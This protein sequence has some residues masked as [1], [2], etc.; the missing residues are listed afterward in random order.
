MKLFHTL[1][2]CLLLTAS[3]GY[4]SAKEYK[5]DD[6]P[7]VHLQDRT[8][9]AIN[10]DGILSA[11]T[12]AAIDTSLFALEQ[13]TGIQVMVAALENIEGGDCFEFA[14]QLGQRH[15][16]GRKEQNSGL[17]ILLVTGERCIQFATGY[18][19]EGVLPDATCK[20]IQV[21]YMNQ[22]FGRGDWDEGMLAGIRV[23]K[24]ILDGSGEFTPGQDDE[25]DDADLWL[26][27]GVGFFCLIVVPALLW[28]DYRQR[29][30]CPHCH[31]YALHEVSRRVLSR[32]GGVR[33]E[34]VTYVCRKCGHT[35]QRTHRHN[36]NNDINRRGGNSGPFIGGMGG[37]LGRGGGFGRGGFGGGSFGGGSFGGG[38]A[39]SKF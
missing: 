36:E 1:L 33:T 26:L 24:G 6:V 8:R 14:Y 18:G 3:A 15:G 19:L 37:G 38:G 30:R 29:T 17:V 22:A 16:V 32:V 2:V 12:V 7:M 21:R 4:M 27:L 5:V 35:V 31:Q 28:Y 11:Q 34:E 10:P 23:V 13:R 20:Q 25:E 9:Y 39:G